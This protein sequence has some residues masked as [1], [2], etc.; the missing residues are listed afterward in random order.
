MSTHD[1]P[2]DLTLFRNLSGFATKQFWL[3]EKG[4]LQKKGA[5]FTSNQFKRVTVHGLAGLKELLDGLPHNI[6][7]TWGLPPLPAFPEGDVVT[8][9]ELDVHYARKANGEIG[10]PKRPLIARDLA[11]LHYEPVPSVMLFDYDPRKPLEKHKPLGWQ[12]LDDIYEEQF[13]GW[14]KL[15]RLYVPSCSSFIRRKSDGHMLKGPGGWHSY[16]IVDDGTR[17]PEIAACL[18]QRFWET[19]HG[20]GE[21]ATNGRFGERTLFDLSMYQPNKPDFA[22]GPVLSD[23]LERD[24]PQGVLLPGGVMLASNYIPGKTMDEWKRSSKERREEYQRL[25]PEAEILQERHAEK[26]VAE[27]LKEKP[28]TDR[29][30]IKKTLLVAAQKQVLMADF[31]LYTPEKVPVTVGELLANKKKWHGQRFADPLDPGH[32]DDWRVA[33]AQLETK[34][35][36]LWSHDHYGGRYELV[37]QEAAVLVRAGENHRVLDDTIEVMGVRDDVFT[38]GGRVVLLNSDGIL[39]EMC[40]Y[41]LAD[42]TGRCIYYFKVKDKEEFRIDPPPVVMKQ[43]AKKKGDGLRKLQAVVT[44]PTMREDGSL[45]R[46]PGY[47]EDTELYL[48]PPHGEHGETPEKVL[49]KFNAALQGIAPFGVE[50]PP[51]HAEWESIT[52]RCALAELMYPFREFPFETDYDRGSYLAQLLTAVIRSSLRTAPGFLIDA[53]MAGSGKTILAFCA[54][55]MAGAGSN[56][57]IMPPVDG[58]EMRKRLLAELRKGSRAIIVDNIEGNFR[59]TALAAFLTSPRFSDR[60][61]ALSES[62]DFPTDTLMMLTGNNAVLEGDLWRRFVRVRLEPRTDNPDKRMFGLEP[63]AYTRRHRMEMTAAA[64]TILR[65][66]VAAGQPRQTQDTVGSFEGWDA[67]VRQCVLWL[68]G[69]GIAGVDDP[70]YA[71]QEMKENDSE[72]INHSALL[73][74]LHE[75]FGNEAFTAAEV[76]ARRFGVGQVD[77]EQFPTKNGQLSDVLEDIAGEWR[78]SNYIVNPKKLGSWMRNKCSAWRNGRRLVDTKKKRHSTTLWRIEC[79]T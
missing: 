38:R 54:A 32:D 21:L 6:F 51:L 49:G 39:A 69:L 41:L 4:Q 9:G 14:K 19:G 24:A 64:L 27:I 74:A 67:L 23:D 25:K 1:I 77:G 30:K 52:L 48:L 33:I 70:A 42:Y 73:A 60:I 2:V 62:A 18:F 35:P 58:D 40:E 57:S 36:Y 44:A 7:V 22:A 66:F 13:P 34:R 12:E 5:D 47:D 17:I 55:I 46:A 10:E 61:M 59:S 78:G 79:R 37:R 26:R 50:G 56:P 29:V 43:I 28:E 3:D 20:W 8:K 45:L 75:A 15:G 31:V 65:R 11:C 72:H 76:I 68:K 53:A 16:I 63:V 71:M